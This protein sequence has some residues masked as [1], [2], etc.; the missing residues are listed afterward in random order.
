[1]DGHAKWFKQ[2]KILSD[3]TTNFPN[4]ALLVSPMLDGG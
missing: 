3:L 1:V 4:Y 2:E